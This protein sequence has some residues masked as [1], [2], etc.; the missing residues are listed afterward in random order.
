M[1]DSRLGL[2]S[3]LFA[4]AAI[5]PWIAGA[6]ATLLLTPYQRALQSAWCGLAPHP[7]SAF[8]GHCTACWIGVAILVA[9]GA[10]ALLTNTGPLALARRTR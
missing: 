6:L 4:V 1:A 10:L 7:F 5:W 2:A 8:V 3:A 9:A